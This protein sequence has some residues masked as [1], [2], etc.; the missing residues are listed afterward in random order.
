MSKIFRI[1]SYVPKELS[2]DLCGF[3]NGLTYSEWMRFYRTKIS[4]KLYNENSVKT[5]RPNVT[6]KTLHETM[7]HTP[8]PQ[9]Y[10][11]HIPIQQDKA[12]KNINKIFVK[13]LEQNFFDFIS[14]NTPLMLLPD[15]KKG[16][17][18]TFDV[19][20]KVEF[21]DRFLEWEQLEDSDVKY[22]ILLFAGSENQFYN[23]LSPY[24]NF[25]NEPTVQKI[26]PGDL[27]IIPNKEEFNFVINTNNLFE[28]IFVIMGRVAL[29][30]TKFCTT[31]THIAIPVIKEIED[32]VMLYKTAHVAVHHG[33]GMNNIYNKIK[34]ISKN[35]FITM[36]QFDKEF[37]YLFKEKGGQ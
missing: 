12:I 4:E 21:Q 15:L 37:G 27:F 10:N 30:E 20:R 35:A 9:S 13:H 26:Q 24:I 11:K 22:N 14:T 17:D 6:V 3:F 7:D 31:N 34:N 23:P 19:I 28:N 33:E 1:S 25:L 8:I 5:L 29:Q 36:S 32:G 2:F 18:I 16:Y